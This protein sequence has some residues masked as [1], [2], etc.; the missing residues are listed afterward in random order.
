VALESCE[1]AFT[2]MPLGRRTRESPV[3]V[4]IQQPED[5]EFKQGRLRNLCQKIPF[6]SIKLTSSLF[7]YFYEDYTPFHGIRFPVNQSKS[8]VTSQA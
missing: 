2:C 3:H 6:R 1:Q 7:D 5:P 4:T 8:Y